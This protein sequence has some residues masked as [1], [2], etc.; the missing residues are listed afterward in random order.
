MLSNRWGN[1]AYAVWTSRDCKILSF[2]VSVD[3]ACDSFV[4]SHVPN[5]SS[6]PV[7]ESVTEDWNSNDM[8]IA[9]AIMVKARLHGVQEKVMQTVDAEFLRI[10]TAQS[11]NDSS[12]RLREDPGASS[13]ASVRTYAA[14]A[15]AGVSPPM[16]SSGQ[17]PTAPSPPSLP[18]GV[19]SMEEWS[20]CY[21]TFG[22]LKNKLSYKEV[23]KD[24]DEEMMG[25]KKYLWSHRNTGSPGLVDLVNYLIAN[26]CDFHENAVTIPGSKIVRNFK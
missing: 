19:N 2:V 14:S 8:K 26:E 4:M 1:D 21:V 7:L 16:P 25:Y 18:D 10:T 11:M 24:C 17:L 20:R 13:H 6:S 3:S 15:S 22:K 12:K 9:V 23:L 5:G